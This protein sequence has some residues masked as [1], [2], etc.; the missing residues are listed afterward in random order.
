MTVAV[1]SACTGDRRNFLRLESVMREG[2]GVGADGQVHEI[3][4]AVRVGLLGAREF[5][6]VAHDGHGGVG[7]DA[8][9]FVGDGAG[10]AAESLLRLRTGSEGEQ[11]STATLPRKRTRI[12]FY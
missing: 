12:W 6:L 10:D 8:A 7:Q 2:E 3:V 1:R 4:G 5:G 9:G 11:E